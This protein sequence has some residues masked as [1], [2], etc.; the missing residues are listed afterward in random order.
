M[1]LHIAAAGENSNSLGSSALQSVDS[2]EEDIRSFVLKKLE[3][4]AQPSGKVRE[5][6]V[7]KGFAKEIFEPIIDR[8]I[9]VG[10]IDDYALAKSYVDHSL[11]RKGKSKTM[12]A[13]ELRDKGL[14]ADAVNEAIATIDADRESD[15]AN[16]IAEQKIRSLTRFDQAERSKKLA[17]FLSR[18]GYA[19]NVVWAAVRH[20]E[21]TLH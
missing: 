9:E 10:L 17:A 15:A 12:I 2:I 20:A 4:T 14:T 13:R 8:F 7:A 3:R 16:A 21:A 19:S 1:E 6:L 11:T 5:A 18:K